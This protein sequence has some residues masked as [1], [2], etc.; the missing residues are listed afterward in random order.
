MSADR[1]LNLSKDRLSLAFIVE[2]PSRS[3]R[4]ADARLLASSLLCGDRENAPCSK[5]EHCR[6][7]Q[8]GIHPDL[9]VVTREPDGSG[10]YKRDFGVGRVRYIVADSVVMPN[11]ADRKVY[12]IPDA[13]LMNIAAQNAFLKSLEEP[14]AGVC[15]ILC[16]GNAGI[17][18]E[19]LRS[20][21]L[22]F[23]SGGTKDPDSDGDVYRGLA[24]E[25][26]RIVS[27]DKPAELLLF[28]LTGE[29]LHAKTL[30]GFIASS[31]ELLVDVLAGRSDYNIGRSEALRLFSLF[32]T[33]SAY[34]KS[35]VGARH[36]L[37]LLASQS[38][39]S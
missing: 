25:Y 3:K 20:R 29:G 24:L 8:S 22:V 30:G 1:P 15:F 26:L 14:P 16:T 18:L 36:I 23:S 33:A 6:K 11:E 31:Q 13:E 2:S 28:F 7:V 39:K 19:T 37:S 9:I 5:C 34:H 4:E 21:C 17:F 32:N 10:G 38:L 27:S 12:L 35:N